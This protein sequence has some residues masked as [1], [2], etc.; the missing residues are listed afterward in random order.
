LG[1]K[2]TPPNRDQNRNT[3]VLGPGQ[4]VPQTHSKTHKKKT[5]KPTSQ[6]KNK[7]GGTR[8]FSGLEEK[9]A[10]LTHSGCQKTSKKKKKKKKIWGTFWAPTKKKVRPNPRNEKHGASCGGWFCTGNS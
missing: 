7:L 10:G 2:P 6:K 9:G 3:T 8:F 5:K 4:K 1:L